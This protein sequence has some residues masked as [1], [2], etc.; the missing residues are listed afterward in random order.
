M[1]YLKKVSGPDIRFIK[2]GGNETLQAVADSEI[3][4][5]LSIFNHHLLI[6]KKKGGHGAWV[7][8]E[9]L[10]SFPNPIGLLKDAPHPMRES[11]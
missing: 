2:G 8:M 9:P 6:Q 1:A 4:I 5:G 10:L 3:L 11:C 7:K